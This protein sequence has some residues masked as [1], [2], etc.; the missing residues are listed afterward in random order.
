MSKKK[1]IKK[2]TIKLRDDFWSIRL[3]PRPD[4]LCVVPD[5]VEGNKTSIIDRLIRLF[6]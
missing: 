1:K 4:S 6:F 2:E 3:L 5:D